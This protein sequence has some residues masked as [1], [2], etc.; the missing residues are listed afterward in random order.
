ME[1]VLAD[2][3]QKE[4]RFARELEVDIELG[5]KN[6]FEMIVS[7]PDW[8]G[9]IEYGCYLYIPGTEFGGM[10]GVIKSSTKQNAIFIC[11]NTWRGM[12]TKKVICPDPGQDYKIV[13]GELN[14]IIRAQIAECGLSSLFVVPEADTETTVEN[15]RFERHC[16]LLSGLEKLLARV[17][18]RLDI[19]YIK[20][21]TDAHVRLQAVPVTDYSNSQEFSQ[22]CKLNFTVNEKRDGINH[23]I[24][25]GKGELK[26]RIEKHI[27]IQ[28]D[29]S[30]GT[31]QYFGTDERAAVY[32]Y[33]SAEEPELTEKGTERLRELMNKKSMNVDI[34]N[35]IEQE[36]QIG[37]IVGGR[38]YITGITVRKPV[39][40]KILTIREGEMNVEY[41]IE[42]GD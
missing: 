35:D 24:C 3:N 30:V 29:G 38:D 14:N 22:D 33:S 6:D 31:E 28:K 9:D 5:E 12:L 40:G 8:T 21:N 39:I 27:Y 20:T 36:L 37:D 26:D 41:R 42:G 16:T 32:D 7:V 18:Y 4:I 17:G 34:T 15:Y 11:G 25:L 1:L 2:K 13:S 10:A 19:A 23:L